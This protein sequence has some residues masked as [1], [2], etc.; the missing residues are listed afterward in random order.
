MVAQPATTHALRSALEQVRL[1]GAIFLRAE[2]QEPWAYESLTGPAT[3][4][5]LA[6]GND[7]IAFFHL[8]AQG[9]CWVEVDQQRHWADAGDVVVLAYGHQHRMGGTQPAEVVSVSSFIPPPPWP[10]M[11][12]IRY[13]A[14]GARTDVVCGYLLSDDVLFDPALQ[15]FPPV[16]VVRP[17]EGPV[18]DWVRAN[19]EYAARQTSIGAGAPD[20]V[21]TRLPEMLLIEVLKLHLAT[22]PTSPSGLLA[23]L[24]DPVLGRALA[25]VHG[26][27]GHKWTVV[28]LASAVSVSRSLLDD[29][30]RSVL[31]IA[32]MHYVTTWRMHR[33]K[34]LLQETTQSVAAIARQVGYDAEEAFS[35]AFKRECGTPPAVWRLHS[36][37]APGEP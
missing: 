8:I 4:G 35:R 19:I 2:Y 18:A 15:V 28:E 13:G 37:G 12:V 6:P 31:G 22:A 34:H 21:T 24:R 25:L 33:A 1:E 10:Q 9:R 32:P 17:P 11:P 5:F 16:F 30:F 36:R 20:G 27:P 7:R 23:A 29:R 3:A 26:A 14:D